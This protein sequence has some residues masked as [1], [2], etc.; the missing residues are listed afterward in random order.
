MKKWAKCLYVLTGALVLTVF[1]AVSAERMPGLIEQWQYST[2]WQAGI[3]CYECHAA[4]KGE[5]DAL[6]HNG[7]VVATIVSPR[8]CAKCHP[9]ES[10]EQEASH[11]AKAGDILNTRRRSR[12]PPPPAQAGSCL[13]SWRDPQAS[14]G[15]TPTAQRAPAPPATPATGSARNSPENRKCAASATSARITRKSR[16]TTSQ[17]TASCTGP[18]RMS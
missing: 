11:H 12:C 13:N 9:K 7:F 1:L 10:A 4:Q 5:V 15:S 14:A 3:G 17:N 8:D 18:S 16:S 6:D 2:H